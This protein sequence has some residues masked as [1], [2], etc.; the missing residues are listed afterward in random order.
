MV[1]P[2]EVPVEPRRPR[3][4]RRWRRHVSR[5]AAAVI[6]MVALVALAATLLVRS[7]RGQRLVLDAVLGRVRG[8]FAGELAVTAIRSPSLLTGATL[9]GVR[10]DAAG[11]RP[12]LLVDSI[13]VRYSILGLIA[14]HPR[15]ASATVWGPHVV[16]SRYSGEDQSNVNRLL[17]PSGPVT[18]STKVTHEIA[19]GHVS[20][21]GGS[22][23]ILS[24]LERG[25]SP[26]VQRVPSPDGTGELR[27]ISLDTLDADLQDVLLR[28]GGTDP[29]AG[30]VAALSLD[31]RVFEK[32][33]RIA[34]AQGHL[35]YGV[36][37]LDL[38]DA[39]V[40]LPSSTLEG[41]VRFG[42]ETGEGS[43]W[44]VAANLRT[45]GTGSLADLGWVD[46]RIPDGSFVGGASVTVGS[47]LDV[48]FHRL[49]V[50]L[51]ASRFRL[52]GDVTLGDRVELGDLDI[53]VHPLL[54]SR[55]EPWLG[56]ELPLNGWLS[57]TL[58]VSGTPAA[59]STNGRLTLVPMNYGSL[60]TTADFRGTVHAGDD[61]GVTNLQMLLEP[62]NFRLLAAFVPGLAIPETGRASLNLSGRVNSGMRMVLEVRADRD[63][64]SA[65]SV[66]VRGSFRRREGD[67]WTTDLQGELSPLSLGLLASLYPELR[68]GG[69]V[70][71]SL[72]A[73]GPLDTL[74][75]TGDLR[76]GGGTARLEGT[77]DAQAIEAGY[78][79]DATLS[80]VRISDL[81]GRVPAPTDWSGRVQVEGRGLTPDSVQ[82][83][84]TVEI[85]GSRVGGLHLDT[86][87]VRMQASKGVLGIDTLMANLGGVRLAGSGR[88]GL[89]G[90]AEG[91][92][93]FRFSSDSLLG[94][95]SIFMGDT[96]LA[97]DTLSAL[98]REL[99]RF[100][101]V[102]PDALPDSA[103]VAMSGSLEGRAHL[104]GS[105]HALDVDATAVLRSGVY[106][107]NRVDSVAMEVSAR[108]LPSSSGTLRFSLDAGGVEVFDRTF[109]GVHVEGDVSDGRGNGAVEVRRRPGEVYAVRGSFALDSVGGAW[110]SRTR[111]PPSIQPPGRWRGPPGSRGIRRRCPSTAC[112]SPEPDRSP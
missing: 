65:S 42:P 57:G 105:V 7:G 71:G 87:A 79:M 13:R 73:V 95:R 3:R 68:L 40:R 61:P 48:R 25:A 78:R 15:V 70:R 43:P 64:A 110:T 66:T 46:P 24:P 2:A 14:G 81:V 84:A 83:S 82:A 37:G 29:F 53:Q 100:Q 49:E 20:I 50:D 77:I 12:F 89:V 31:A 112:T 59:L 60:P 74:R 63:S 10:L 69:T 5:A 56:R 96:V 18:D 33:L 101:G 75:L 8:V 76:G 55:L 11:G 94:L 22:V 9:L 111:A 98:E 4:R 34:D 107:L 39:T 44:A 109:Q 106:R 38:Q 91:E 62:F 88:V 92:A 32:P 27:R 36:G 19:L 6:V 35:T 23:E 41:E 86:V 26:R 21:R 93:D 99:L 30:T 97:R 28:L 85:G 16:V 104:A 108:G 103:E 80:G 1:D 67:G 17:R 47:S 52:D 72:R 54:V 102:N 45:R 58:T 51:E 90:S